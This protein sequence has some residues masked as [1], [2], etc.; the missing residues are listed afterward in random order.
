MFSVTSIYEPARTWI[1]EVI[2]SSQKGDYLPQGTCRR[3]KI[4]GGVKN[5]ERFYV[6]HQL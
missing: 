4:L 3:K 2:G 5:H 6:F 1:A